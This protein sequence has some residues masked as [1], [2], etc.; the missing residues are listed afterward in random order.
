MKPSPN[1]SVRRIADDPLAETVTQ[2]RVVFGDT[3][4][5]GHA[6][7]SRYLLLMALARAHYLHR[8]GLLKSALTNCWIMSV[9]TV[10]VDF[11]RPLG[12]FEKFEIGTQVLSW[13]DRRFFVRQTFRS[14][15]GTVATG[16]VKVIVRSP[17]GVVEPARV[18]RTLCSRD[19]QPPMLPA[20]LRSRFG[21]GR[22]S[23]FPVHASPHARRG[24]GHPLVDIVDL[25]C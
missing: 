21:V 3:D 14:P 6:N 5:F 12:P 19:V 1:L 16:Y 9:A 4:L 22:R 2:W 25:P 23:A 11:Y 7:N 18:A 17:S 10:D 20:G 8:A 24:S 15:R 13:D